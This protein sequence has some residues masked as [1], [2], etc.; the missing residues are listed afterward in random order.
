[1]TTLSTEYSVYIQETQL[2]FKN[3]LIFVKKIKRLFLKIKMS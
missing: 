1:M 3:N 2:V